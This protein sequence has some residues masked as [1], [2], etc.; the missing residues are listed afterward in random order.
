[1][2]LLS[3]YAEANLSSE[4]LIALMR[5]DGFNY[6]D[7]GLL[8]GID[9]KEV[10]IFARTLP[11]TNYPMAMIPKATKSDAA[12]GCQICHQPNTYD[13]LPVRSYNGI[14]LYTL[15]YCALCQAVDSEQNP[16]A[17]R[18]TARRLAAKEKATRTDNRMGLHQIPYGY[19]AFLYAKQGGVCFY[20]DRTLEFNTRKEL[21][22]TLSVDRVIF[23]GEYEQGNIVLAI[24]K[25][26][27]MKSDMT[28]EEMGKWTP[29]WAIRVE[30]F[31]SNKAD[32]LMEVH[33][34]A[35]A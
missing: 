8:L 1:M 15:S 13:Q 26:N 12:F 24:N 32:W 33:T 21:S 4:T 11:Q 20:S 2:K 18:S 29:E 7:I 30:A 31:Q 3:T 28:L 34:D 27:N 17:A 9:R 16:L 25:V 19:F 6:Q 22:N 14:P 23:S 5:V 10:S 35:T